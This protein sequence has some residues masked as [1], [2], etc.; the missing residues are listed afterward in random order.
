MLIR[1]YL[2]D[3]GMADVPVA[4]D[5]VRLPPLIHLP[6]NVE[7]DGESL[8]SC[9]WNSDA[10]GK[11]SGD[12]RMTDASVARSVRSPPGPVVHRT[13]QHTTVRL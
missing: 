3:V 9:L 13:G 7:R 5:V 11:L 12:V 10:D 2:G 4:R 6:G 1:N 8:I